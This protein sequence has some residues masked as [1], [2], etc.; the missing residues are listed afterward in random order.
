MR[1]VIPHNGGRHVIA[2]LRQ[3][4]IDVREL[5]IV[6]F[7]SVRGMGLA[8]LGQVGQ[9]LGEFGLISGF[10]NRRQQ[11]GDQKGNDGNHHQQLN[12]GEPT[13][14]GHAILLLIGL[15][16][17][18]TSRGFAN[19]LNHQCDMI[20]H[21]ED[22]PDGVM[23]LGWISGY[24][25]QCAAISRGQCGRRRSRWLRRPERRQQCRP[26]QPRRRLQRSKSP[27]QG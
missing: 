26:P 11:D 25:P 5:T 20:D 1:L 8:Q 19:P 21:P 10:A 12:N 2:V 22:G 7:R 13:L 4:V 16:T 6:P 18:R 27:S 23:S 9:G 3:V 17:V 15:C 14:S 24:G